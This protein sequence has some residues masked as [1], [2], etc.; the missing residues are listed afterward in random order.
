M[1]VA[2]VARSRTFGSPSPNFSIASRSSIRGLSKAC[3]REGPTR[4]SKG[5]RA[6]AVT[7]A[8]TTTTHVEGR[9]NEPPFS[10]L[11]PAIK[12]R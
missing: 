8:A 6:L 2:S 10:Q 12:S 1:R 11:R 3:S 7:S 5:K 9:L 4:P